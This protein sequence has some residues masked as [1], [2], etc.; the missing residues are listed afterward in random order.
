MYNCLLRDGFFNFRYMFMFQLP[1]LAETILKSQDLEVLA[2]ILNDP[3]V[4][5]AKAG[6]FTEE[7]INAYKY[8]ASLPGDFLMELQHK[9]GKNI[10]VE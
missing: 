5:G 4:V 7:D 3:F 2:R 9:C 10:L 1:Y 8:A 6:T